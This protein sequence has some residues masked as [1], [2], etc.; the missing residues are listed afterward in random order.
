MLL[1]ASITVAYKCPACGSFEFFDGISIFELL[2]SKKTEM[3]CKCGH[4]S[5]DILAEGLNKIYLT[6][7][8]FSCEST[9]FFCITRKALLHNE[10]NIFVCPQK[11]IKLCFVGSDEDVRTRID[12]FEKELDELIDA[13]GYENYFN[14]NQVMLDS[15]NHLHDI[16][17]KGELCCECGRGDI[18][19]TLLP[20][21]IMLKCR[22]CSATKELFAASNVN[23]KEI[24]AR[25]KITL[26]KVSP[27]M[28]GF[29]F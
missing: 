16:A 2:H 10:T 7:P 5:V 26:A 20:D 21:R 3:R 28:D 8:C 27:D 22:D 23:L 18:E 17:E 13:F 4:S 12:Y 19:V 29:R 14:N 1:N 25:N 15:L 9:H 24:M 6:V 11:G